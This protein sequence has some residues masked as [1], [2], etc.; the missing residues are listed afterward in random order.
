MDS[1]K[2]VNLGFFL[3]YIT[4]DL[5]PWFVA[6]QFVYDKSFNQVILMAP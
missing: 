6:R 4:Y 2:C 3:M 5:K 1:T